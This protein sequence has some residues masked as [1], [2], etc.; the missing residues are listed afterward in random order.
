MENTKGKLEKERDGN[1]TEFTFIH[2]PRDKWI[3]VRSSTMNPRLH[4]S[5]GSRS[6]WNFLTSRCREDGIYWTDDLQRAVWSIEKCVYVCLCA[7]ALN[8]LPAIPPTRDRQRY[9]NDL[10]FRRRSLGRRNL[11]SSS[12]YNERCAHEIKLRKSAITWRILSI[13]PFYVDYGART[14]SSFIQ[15]PEVHL[16][17]GLFEWQRNIA[18]T[19]SGHITTLLTVNGSALFRVEF[20]GYRVSR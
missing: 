8:V 7:C 17:A 13:C 4:H 12:F 11:F 5:R 16:V 14:R 6:K 19:R 20:R 18:Q 2:Q 9:H 10:H 15:F 1:A 3:L